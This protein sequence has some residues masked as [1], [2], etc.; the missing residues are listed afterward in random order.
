M[1]HAGR[2]LWRTRVLATRLTSALHAA[3]CNYFA[4]AHPRPLRLYSAQTLLRDKNLII[5]DRDLFTAKAYKCVSKGEAN[6]AWVDAAVKTGPGNEQR[7]AILFAATNDGTVG[8]I[9][10][11]SSAPNTHLHQNL[12]INK[13][14]FLATKR[15]ERRAKA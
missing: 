4:V 11:I 15:D 8:N 9:A 14:D 6:L 13:R 12:V 2:E 5:L 7:I 3:H 10:T 1:R